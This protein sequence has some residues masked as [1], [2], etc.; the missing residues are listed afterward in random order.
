MPTLF[1]L[2]HAASDADSSDSDHDRPLNQCG[3]DAAVW[4]G[5]YLERIGVRPQRVLCSS[6]RRALETWSGLASVWSLEADRLA[7]SDQLY[8][9]STGEMLE[10]LRQQPVD[11]ESVLV[12]AHNPGT[13]ELALMLAG[14]GER[15][16]YERLRDQFPEAALCELAFDCA[17]S[18]LGPGVAR[19]LRFAFAPFE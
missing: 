14:E 17:W 16:A 15:D 8:L 18:E 13:H 9:A 2:R 11:V 19:L 4:M 5:G 1:L 10:L 12:I 3:A 7:E 6:A